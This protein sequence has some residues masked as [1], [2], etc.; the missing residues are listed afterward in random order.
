MLKKVLF[1]QEDEAGRNIAG[2]LEKDYSVSCNS[3]GGSVLYADEKSEMLPEADLFI[4]A[5]RHK[6]ESGTPSLTVHPPGNY[7]AAEAGGNK[8][9]LAIAPALYLSDAFHLLQENPLAGYE[10]CLEVTH[11]GPTS[12]HAPIMFVEV[13]STEKEW[14]DL[15]ACRAAAK[16]IDR[17]LNNEPKDI[18]AAIGFGGGHYCRKFSLVREYA[19]GHICPK[20]NLMHL[21]NAMLDEMINKTIPAPSYALIEKKGVGSH[22][23]ELLGLLKETCL[24]IVFL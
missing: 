15:D 12:L 2:V 6:S 13:G 18:P 19:L 7:L 23:D 11:H 5:S 21:D 16:T 14:R 17:I 1:S 10:V 3:L 24:D 9:Q 8:K 22:R 20:Y 4:V